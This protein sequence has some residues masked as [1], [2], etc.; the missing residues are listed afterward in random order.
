MTT[1][2]DTIDLDKAL[3][4]T[5]ETA[6]NGR[7]LEKWERAIDASRKRFDLIADAG[8]VN[9]DRE[10][11]FAMQHLIKSDFTLKVAN[12]NPKSVLVA[13]ANVAATG[14]TLNPALKLA[15]LVPRDGAIRLDISYMGLLQIATDTG[16]IMW[17]RADVVREADTFTYCGPAAAPEHK[18]NPFATDRGE[19]VGA[20][21]IAKTHT[22]DILCGI[23]TRA[24]LDTVRDRSD[25]W[26]MRDPARGKNG[27]PWFDF[28]EEMSKKA[29]IKRD[30]KTWPRTDQHKRLADAV[31]IANEAEGGYTFDHGNAVPQNLIGDDRKERHDDA[32]E[33]YA[34]AVQ[35]VKLAIYRKDWPAMADAWAQIPSAAQMDLYLAPSKGGIFSTHERKC[36]HDNQRKASEAEPH[37]GYPRLPEGETPPPE[38][39]Q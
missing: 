14:L 13:M 16:S 15:Y 26:K 2:T 19:I 12:Q 31:D 3:A 27:G 38:L 6:P 5:P 11:M 23:M 18:C 1:D 33:Q 20:Y 29:V 7:K 9:Y 8:S 25:A 21:V 37:P 24:E 28:P 35:A 32:A 22:G 17:G 39:Q 36:L 30:Q 34:E 4:A 10:A